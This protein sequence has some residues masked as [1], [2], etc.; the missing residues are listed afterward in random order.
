MEILIKQL[1]AAIDDVRIELESVNERLGE[2]EHSIS[3]SPCGNYSSKFKS[4]IPDPLLKEAIAIAK[5]RGKIT[6]S[7]LQRKLQVGYARAARLIDL[8]EKLNKKSE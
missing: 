8:M 2:I 6:A 1:I 3:L 4:E 7:V 5:K